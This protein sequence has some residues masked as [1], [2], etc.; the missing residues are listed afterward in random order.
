M[1]ITQRMCVEIVIPD[2][3]NIVIIRIILVIHVKDVLTFL[4]SKPFFLQFSQKIGL[5]NELN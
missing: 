5:S 4:A 1:R 2:Q 3:Q